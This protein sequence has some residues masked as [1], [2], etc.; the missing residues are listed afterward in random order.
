MVTVF[1]DEPLNGPL[2]VE[3]ILGQ[4]VAPFQDEASFIV[5]TGSRDV[6]GFWSQ[7]IRQYRSEQ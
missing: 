2:E 1:S 7:G 6:E 4:G 3:R 5:L